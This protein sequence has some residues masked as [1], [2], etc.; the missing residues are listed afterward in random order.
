MGVLVMELP[1]CMEFEQFAKSK[2]QSRRSK[3]VTAIAPWPVAKAKQAL[4]ALKGNA[5]AAGP[6]EMSSNAS[7][8]LMKKRPSSVSKANPNSSV[9]PMASLEEAAPAIFQSKASKIVKKVGLSLSKP[10]TPNS[11]PSTPDEKVKPVLPPPMPKAAPGRS[12]RQR[13]APAKL[14]M[15]VKYFLDDEHPR[16]R[17]VGVVVTIFQGSSY[18]QM[19]RETKPTT[20]PGERV[21]TYSI[22]CRS[23][24]HLHHCL[25]TIAPLNSLGAI[26]RLPVTALELLSSFLSDDTWR[27]LVEDVRK[28]PADSVVFN[29]ECCSACGV[30][31]F[32]C[33]DTDCR[34][35]SEA[36]SAT[37]AFMGFALR[38]GYTVMCSDFSLKSLIF[39]W[40]ESDLGPNP[41][42][43]VGDC[44][45]QFC[46][47]FV[48]AELQHEEVPQ[49]LQVVGE[50]CAEQGKAVVS[51]MGNT[52]VYTVNPR[53][54]ATQMYDLKVLTVVTDMGDSRIDPN[55]TTARPDDLKSSIG[56]GESLRSGWAGH[57]TLTYPG[58][59]QLI[60]S[61]GHWVELSK[62][63]TS[64]E[65]V[66][67]VARKNFGVEESESFATEL[68]TATNEVER[69]RIIQKSAKAMVSKSAPSRM[70]CRTKF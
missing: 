9:K 20:V 33:A 35:S 42:L 49:Q 12:R 28:V 44:S 21:S 2:T 48:P 32:P 29:W 25:R 63:D 43:S 31:A 13:A 23:V 59:G 16:D 57:V 1:Q 38:S 10:N 17:L 58:G 45:S 67:R 47:E 26:G 70:K 68:A 40:S 36:S 55:P 15:P 64:V 51:A 62:I 34:G 39:E 60:T 5:S 7:K 50:L 30:H 8:A 22:S 24:G 61:M 56:D 11:I 19:F 14:E 54:P 53:R 6:L 66:L 69:S 46:L 52:I 65:S 3:S 37:M 4:G 27:S 41:F 18:D